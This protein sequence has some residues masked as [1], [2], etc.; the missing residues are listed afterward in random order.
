[1]FTLG[2]LSDLHSTSLRGAEVGAFLNKRLFGWL[3]WNVR[4]RRVHRPEVLEALLDDLKDQTPDHIVVTGDLTNVALEQEFVAT[5]DWLR[6]L[7]DPNRVTV[8]PGNHD[9]YVPVARERSWDHWAEYLASDAGEVEA[10]RAKLGS[11]ARAASD[12]PTVRVRSGIALVGVSS[13][14]PTPAF[15]A[16]G[17]VGAEQLERLE[18]RLRD[19]GGRGLGRVVL[20]HHPPTDQGLRPSRRLKDSAALRAVFAR[21]GADLV[22]HG[23]YHRRIIAWIPG[24]SGAIPAVGVPSASRVGRDKEPRRAKYHLYQIEAKQTAEN[25][26]GAPNYRVR[27][28]VRGY[29]PATGQFVAEGEQEL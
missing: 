5:A 17:M 25:L 20:I 23:H 3:S 26:E 24:P 9:A 16:T 13:A 19:L 4:R 12:F 18:E 6:R 29:N 22:L 28:F 10:D 2:H 14:L 11:D 8:V 21:V 15:R 1:M 27:M 7:G